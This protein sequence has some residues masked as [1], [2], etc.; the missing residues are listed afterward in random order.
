MKKASSIIYGFL[1]LIFIPLT[2]V[3]TGYFYG[4]NTGT[5]TGIVLGLLAMI[6]GI[7]LF[8]LS[9]ILSGLL[10]MFLGFIVTMSFL[11]YKKLAFGTQ[12][13]N[14]P[15]E[16][17]IN[18]KSATKFTFSDSHFL[19]SSIGT[20]VSSS[21]NKG[22]GSTS[23]VTYKVAPVVG[24]NWSKDK[25]ISVWAT[26]I[27]TCNKFWKKQNINAGIRKHT[28]GKGGFEVAVKDAERR[29]QIRSAREII[30]IEWR[31]DFESFKNRYAMIIKWSF[32]ICTL[33]WS[34]SSIVIAL[35]K[36]KDPLKKEF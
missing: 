18:H 8:G 27:D 15:V 19:S 12:V 14:I 7:F 29:Y 36:P 28:L 22:T 33:I 21:Y 3:I 4:M 25:P 1:C 23:Y 6:V 34:I 13:D 35:S 20:F 24:N 31:N 16:T 26:C 9:H 10:S 11:E 30:F 2:G 32:I 17:T 5:T